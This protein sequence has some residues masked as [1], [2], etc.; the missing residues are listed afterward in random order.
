MAPA[1]RSDGE[2]RVAEAEALRLFLKAQRQRV[3]QK[4][5]AMERR[6]LA[7]RVERMEDWD[8]RNL[9]RA[10]SKKPGLDFYDRRP[11]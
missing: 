7:A 6:I 8:S 1:G 2:A 5:A 9:L 11:W 3:G 4:L 10:G